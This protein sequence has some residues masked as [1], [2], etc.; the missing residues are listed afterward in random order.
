MTNDRDRAAPYM[1]RLRELFGRLDGAYRRAAEQYGFSCRGCDQTCCGEHFLHHT[2]AEELLLAEGLETLGEE[3]RERI[4]RRA[5]DV[6]TLYLRMAESGEGHQVY[7]P[8]FVDGLCSLYEYRPLICRLHGIPYDLA[9][10]DGQPVRGEGCHKFDRE[11]A[12]AGRPYVPFD[13]TAWFREMAGIE[14]GLRRELLF[15]GKNRKTVAGMI[16]D[17]DRKRPAP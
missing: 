5:R 8:L 4:V 3:V 2:L 11:I 12:G 7:C 6:V 16:V 17:I 9:G 14:I 15:G 13:R 10:P 1:K